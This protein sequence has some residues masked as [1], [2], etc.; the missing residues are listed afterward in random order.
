MHINLGE[1]FNTFEDA[2]EFTN[3]LVKKGVKYFSY[4]SLIDICEN[5]HSFFGDVCPICGEKSVTKGIKIV[6]Y[7]V[8]MNSFKKER[9]QELGERKFYDLN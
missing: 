9:K 6:G 5:D 1:N 3:G 8:K 7:L 2:W 4:I